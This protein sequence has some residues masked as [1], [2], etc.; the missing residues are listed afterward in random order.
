ME[1]REFSPGS[2]ERQVIDS[3]GV[4]RDVPRGWILVP[5]G[6]AALTR[7]I[8]Q[9]GDFWIVQERKG[10]KVF[11]RGV[12]APEETVTSIQ[13]ELEVERATEGF[14]KRR[15]ADAKRREK[16]QG[17]YVGDFHAAVVEFLK[18]H[19]RH[20]D[21]AE[22]FAAAVVTHATP[23]GSGTVARTKRI[24]IEKRA[25]AAVIAWMRHQT[26]AYDTMKIARVKGE[27]REVRR[28]LAERSRAILDAYRRGQPV[29]PE[30]PLVAAVK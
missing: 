25:S 8:K 24:P 26:T 14:A 13:R 4:V 16:V 15:E 17:Q 22:K 7:R 23:V 12:W 6:D 2:V 1:E 18:F 3:K 28:Q 10:R 9:A 27:R 29:D 21:L 30:C 11:S 5:P 20:A 19:P